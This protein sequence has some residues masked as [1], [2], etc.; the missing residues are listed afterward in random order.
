MC[1]R[2]FRV[3]HTTPLDAELSPMFL[4]RIGRYLPD[5]GWKSS[6][7]CRANQAW[8]LTDRSAYFHKLWNRGVPTQ[9]KLGGHHRAGHD[10]LPAL[11]A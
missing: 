6:P 11:V 8:Y 3:R 9:D 4:H 10:I 7:S 5:R 2:P 1:P